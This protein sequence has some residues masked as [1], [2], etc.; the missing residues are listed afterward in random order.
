ME[1]LVQQQRPVGEE[2][3]AAAAQVDAV[4]T[5]GR[6][7]PRMETHEDGVLDHLHVADGLPEKAFQGQFHVFGRITAITNPHVHLPMQNEPKIRPSRSSAVKIPVTS[8]NALCAILSS[9]ATSSP[10]RRCCSS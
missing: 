5:R 8:S 6:D 4:G 10:A 9:S 2:L 3:V 7:G 1:V